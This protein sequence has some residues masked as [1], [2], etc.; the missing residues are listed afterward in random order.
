[1]LNVLLV[2]DEFIVRQGLKAMINWDDYKM[3]VLLEANNGKDALA[4]LEEH[5][6]DVIV[7]DIRMPLMDGIELTR[8]AKESYPDMKVM[9]LTCYDDFEYVQEAVALGASGYL[10]K[11]DLEGGS[12]E[13][14]LQKI[15]KEF[16]Q[17]REMRESYQRLEMKA[18]ES[19]ALMKEKQI[20][21]ILKG[22]EPELSHQELSWLS[23]PHL[24]LKIVFAYP[25]S[26]ENVEQVFYRLFVRDISFLFQLED[27]SFLAL[28]VFQLT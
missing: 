20:K 27:H 15:A 13:K 24:M 1:M 10:L 6:I 22:G 2:D 7:T 23:T 26:H 9:L 28:T 16:Q 3:N 11:T 8:K 4:L 19:A 21:S 14:Q 5:Q 17:E 12:L 18:R 25:V